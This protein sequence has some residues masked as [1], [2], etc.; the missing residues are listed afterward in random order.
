MGIVSTNAKSIAKVLQ[1][2]IKERMSNDTKQMANVADVR[3]R[4]NKKIY[5]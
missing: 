2:I 4:L 3:K 5:N 1:E